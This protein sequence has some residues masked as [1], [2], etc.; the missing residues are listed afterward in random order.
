MWENGGGRSQGSSEGSSAGDHREAEEEEEDEEEEVKILAASLAFVPHHG[1]NTEAIA[2]GARSLG[3]SGAVHGIF[4][5]GGYA[6]IS[7]FDHQC[8]EKLTSH[9]KQLSDPQRERSG[10]CGHL[11]T[12]AALKC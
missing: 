2:E 5:R 10:H 12:S 11:Q 4:P 9:L 3:I 1:W 7:F 6:I 8:N